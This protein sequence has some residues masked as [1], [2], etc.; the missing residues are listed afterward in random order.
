MTFG[1]T[2]LSATTVGT[3]QVPVSAVYVPGTASSNLTALEGI[4]VNTDA[5]AQ[6]SSAARMGL[7]DGDHVTFGA[8]A[9]AV[10]TSDT[11]TF[12]LMALFKRLLQ[13]YQ[14][15]STPII[16]EDQIRALIAAGQGFSVTT[17]QLSTA[18]NTNIYIA[19][20]ILA[21]NIAK[22]IYIYQ[23][24][25]MLMQVYGDLQMTVAISLDAALS[26]TLTPLNDNRGSAT[27]SLAT[28]KST[29]AANTAPNAT[30]GTVRRAYGSASNL[31]VTEMLKQGNGI[32]LPAG[33]TQGVT[34]WVKAPAAGNTGMFN[35]AWVEF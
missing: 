23:W 19:L 12:T 20:G 21:N 14:S 7:L 25:G 28:V 30:S 34:A 35:M 29:P 31:G 26:T 27:T 15:T 1:A 32:Y 22:N 5:N 4:A 16:T 6:K 11:G 24:D 9:D 17:G 2:D 33:S 13:K 3:N 18:T 8:E 10:A